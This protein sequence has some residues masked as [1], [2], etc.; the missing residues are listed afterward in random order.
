MK[1]S[2]IS[3]CLV[4]AVIIKLKNNILSLTFCIKLI[5]CYSILEYIIIH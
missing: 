4:N 1:F 2:E 3:Y 5:L